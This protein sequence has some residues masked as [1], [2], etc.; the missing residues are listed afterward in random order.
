M[1]S[2]E[3]FR[4]AFERAPTVKE[5]EVLQ[6]IDKTWYEEHMQWRSQLFVD[7]FCDY[8]FQMHREKCRLKLP[9]EG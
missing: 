8:Y 6:R 9:E 5:E 1:T 7:Y 2:K 4:K 3:R